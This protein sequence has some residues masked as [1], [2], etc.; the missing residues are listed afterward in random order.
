ML[1]G[2]T[3]VAVLLAC[4]APEASHRHRSEGLSRHQQHLLPGKAPHSGQGRTPRRSTVPD[5]VRNPDK[6][7]CY[8]LDEP[9][10]VGEGDKGVQSDGGRAEL[11]KVIQPA[12]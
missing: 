6:Y 2:R 3:K 12:K 10:T 7:T 4:R 11:E 5:H 9:L 1:S 8:V